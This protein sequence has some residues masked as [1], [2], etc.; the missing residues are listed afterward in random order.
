[1]VPLKTNDV[2]ANF[3]ALKHALNSNPSIA[4]VSGGGHYPGGGY[5][6][7]DHWAEGYGDDQGIS[8]DAGTAQLDYFE[9][10]QIP[11][12]EGRAFSKTFSTDFE[13]AVMI[14]ATAAKMLGFTGSVV[15]KKM[16][17]SGPSDTSRSA[18]EII[19]VFQDF[20][21]WSLRESI[22]PLIF[23]PRERVSN[24]I[25]R[26]NAANIKVTLD[27]IEQQF[28]QVNPSAPYEFRFLDEILGEYY[29]SEQNLSAII[30]SF[31]ILA[32]LIACL[33]LLGLISFTVEK[34][35]KE[36]GVRKVLG[37]SVSNLVLMLS[38]EFVMLVCIANLTAWPVAWVAMNRWLQGFAYRIDISWWT[39]AL[40]GGAALLIA[41]SA[42]STLAIKAALANPVDS[43][44]YE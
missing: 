25:V 33:G 37:A 26:V 9:T 12:I 4:S 15:G 38:K 41:L 43:L 7:W 30:N 2:R 29:Q 19:G 28:R 20:N 14:N 23:Y 6:T 5:V 35:T 21:G 3:E 39:F 11:V 32:I 40:A 44:R 17:T 22:K 10:L 31:A 13:N 42:V 16:F 1:I 8:I 34:K 24:L 18:R 36:I 27:F